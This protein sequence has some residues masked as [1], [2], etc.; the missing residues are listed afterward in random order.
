[1]I[2]NARMYSVN[3]ATSAA[4]HTLLEWVIARAGVACEVIDYPAP[5]P[6]PAL[7]A[8]PDL[9]CAFMCGFPFSLATP[10]LALLA[11]PVP[12]APPFGGEPVYWTDFVVRADSHFQRL[13]DTFGHR[14]AYT[15]EG[16]QSGYQAP[17]RLL[18]P[19]ARARGGRLFAATVGPLQTP[20]RIVD[21]V[22]DGQADVGPLDSYAHELLRLT[23]PGLA[24]QLRVVGV[25]APTTMPPLVAAPGIAPAEVARLREALCATAQASG[26]AE[27]CATLGLRR[28]VPMAA[29]R[30]QR[31]Q[32]EAREADA[33]GYRYLA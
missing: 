1:M 29:E 11:A 17:R 12:S 5:L 24:A 13:E 19:H 3:P 16:S 9:G 6:L 8:R 23:E 31:L 4:W 30:Y 14:L 32:D 33:L 21:A 25:T 28:F 10:S 26:L 7:W 20:R 15:T 22:L 27:V 18:A 2:A